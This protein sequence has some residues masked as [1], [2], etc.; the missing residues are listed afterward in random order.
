MHHYYRNKEKPTVKQ[1]VSIL[2]RLGVYGT[3]I[4]NNIFGIP[5]K[6]GS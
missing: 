5:N 4:Q 1:S 3:K 2:R 6:V